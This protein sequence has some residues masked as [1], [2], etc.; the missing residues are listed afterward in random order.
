L[1][2]VLV[3]L[4]GAGSLVQVDEETA[5]AL[6]TPVAAQNSTPVTATPPQG[7][8]KPDKGLTVRRA[9]GRPPAGIRI[10]PAGRPSSLDGSFIKAI[11][12]EALSKPCEK[13]K[14]YLSA[15]YGD[16]TLR[17]FGLRLK[18]RMAALGPYAVFLLLPVFAALTKLLYW[19]RKRYY[20]EHLVYAL[21][22]HSFAF[23]LL[24]AMS[25]LAEPAKVILMFGGMA[26]FWI[27][28]QRVFGGRW[29]MTG[30]RYCTLGLIY[31]L[32]L[33]L[34]VGFVFLFAI[35]V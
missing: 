4:F 24:L 29:W 2:F 11:E 14:A 15:K 10:G 27:A 25:L 18:E 34:S 35:F 5:S 12:C 13:I 23:L 31:P 22:V 3:K 28:M 17:E 19:R 1:F 30:L 6:K 16:I 26:Y 7:E 32:L 9:D 33:A 21:H 8:S 20:S